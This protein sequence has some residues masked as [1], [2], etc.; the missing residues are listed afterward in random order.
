MSLH[1]NL[2]RI[3]ERAIDSIALSI[4]EG[5]ARLTRTVGLWRIAYSVW[6]PDSA[7][8]RLNES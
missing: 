2:T 8:D 5:C 3:L 6:F 4:V 7:K 1:V